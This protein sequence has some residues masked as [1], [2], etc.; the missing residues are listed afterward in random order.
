V[1]REVTLSTTLR[2]KLRSNQDPIALEQ[3]IA[4]EGRRA[5]RDLYVEVARALDADAV[6]SSGGT[7]QR[8][9]TRWIATLI[10]RLRLPRYR[11]MGDRRSFHPLDERLLLD[12]S[13]ASPAIVASA[14][15][16]AAEGLTYRQ[17]AVVLTHFTGAPFSPQTVWRMLRR[18]NG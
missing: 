4:D 5:A 3:A 2:V 14:R 15:T 9:D 12:R 17:L 16:L 18:H 1:R 6:R 7:R 8:L 11:V 13:E 10:G